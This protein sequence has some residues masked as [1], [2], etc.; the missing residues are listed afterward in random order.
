MS[1]AVSVTDAPNARRISGQATATIMEFYGARIVPCAITGSSQR[2][3]SI[4]RPPGCLVVS[5]ARA[6]LPGSTMPTEPP[7]DD[8]SSQVPFAFEARTV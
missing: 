6:A 4:A 8:A 1:H 5:L 2:W 7:H 3:A